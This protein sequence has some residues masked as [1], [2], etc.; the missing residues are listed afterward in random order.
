MGKDI[1][2]LLLK[3]SAKIFKPTNLESRRIIWA[4]SSTAFIFV[5]KTISVNPIFNS[6][7]QW[8]A[9]QSNKFHES[10]KISSS[11]YICFIGC[12]GQGPCFLTPS[13]E[14][15]RWYIILEHIPRKFADN[16]TLNLSYESMLVV[17]L[18]KDLFVHHQPM[19][20]QHI[21]K[22]CFLSLW[23]TKKVYWKKN[24]WWCTWGFFLPLLL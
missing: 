1:L 23:A 20:A 15:W 3:S 4:F 5:G 13:L 24:A 8:K 11:Y 19:L 16:W 6:L 12:L 14:S 21:L 9:L 7:F 17:L 10:I 2:F 18:A 22:I